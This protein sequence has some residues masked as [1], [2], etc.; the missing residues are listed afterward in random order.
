[1]AHALGRHVL[2]ELYDCDRGKLDD[3]AYLKQQAVAAAI[4]MGATIVGTHAHRY[5]PQGVSVVIILAESHLS[6]HTWPEHGLASLDVFVCNPDTD[7][8]VA[9]DHLLDAL[10][11]DRIA[12]LAVDRGRL[13]Q[14]TGRLARMPD[15]GP[16]QVNQRALR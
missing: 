14:A 13:E 2:A 10:E 4:A 7:P 9:R 16:F 12:E 6:L 1:M 8:R 3:E 11:A 5:E 15:R